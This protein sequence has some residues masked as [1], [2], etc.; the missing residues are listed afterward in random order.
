MADNPPYVLAPGTLAK[1]LDKIKAA[2]TPE[3]FT[4]DFLHTKLGMKGG[5]SNA[6]IP[7]LKRT[8]FLNGDGTPAE[9][10]RQFRNP[11]LSGQ[12][13]A[14]AMKKGYAPL[15][16]MNEYVHDLKDDELRGVIAQATGLDHDTR[17]AGAIL[18]SI[19]T[20]KKFA[21]FDG[22]T[23]TQDLE[24][25]SDKDKE[26]PKS[27]LPRSS[28]NGNGEAQ[29]VGVNLSYTI[30]PNLPATTDVKVF[31]A[32]FRSFREHLLKQ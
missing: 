4:L 11:A 26:I 31:D 16:E 2:A 12:A 20:L 25:D 28:P 7:F 23:E 32:I 6:V 10:Y 18:G 29:G 30:N 21:K 15:Y 1:A 13:V 17:V 27:T 8:G 5:T 9:L 14:R 3:R 22:T 24:K 19:R